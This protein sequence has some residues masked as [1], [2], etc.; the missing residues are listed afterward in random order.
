[1]AERIEQDPALELL[2]P[3]RLSAVC[4]RLKDCSD[5]ENQA[6]L[7]R[8]VDEGT[9]LLGPAQIRGRFGLRACMANYRTQREDI[10]LVLDRI[11]RLAE[12]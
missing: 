12:G 9:A 5:T 4:L 11:R 6:V 1:M 3:V 7:K 10:D 2:A 8:M